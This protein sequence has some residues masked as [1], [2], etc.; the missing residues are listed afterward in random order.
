MAAERTFRRPKHPRIY[1]AVIA[2]AALI[3]AAGVAGAWRVAQA[4]GEGAPPRVAT[5]LP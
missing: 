4:S 5:A 1:A 2:L 3:L